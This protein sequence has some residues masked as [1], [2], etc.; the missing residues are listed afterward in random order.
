MVTVHRISN[1]PYSVEYGYAEIK[2]IA[3]E[4]RTVPL[5]WISPAANDVEQPL[6]DYLFPLIQGESAVEY[7]NG[8]PVYMNVSHLSKH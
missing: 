2:N 7:K 5:E 6:I 1:S 4:A 3:N 8:L